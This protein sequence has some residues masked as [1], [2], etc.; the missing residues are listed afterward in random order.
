VVVRAEGAGVSDTHANLMAAVLERP[1]DDTARLVYADWLD[2]HADPGGQC[3]DCDGHGL[4]DD[5]GRG[6]S[7]GTTCEACRG[8]GGWKS[9]GHRERAEFIR[10]QCRLS[11]LAPH[12]ETS[13]ACAGCRC[14][15]CQEYDGLRRREG[16][17]WFRVREAVAPIGFH[18]S[19]FGDGATMGVVAGDENANAGYVVRRGFVD[20]IRLPMARFVGGP[21][22]R[23]E[24]DGTLIGDPRCDYC[25]GDGRVQDPD[26]DERAVIDCD[27]CDR[28]DCPACTGTGRTPGL[29]LAAVWGAH[30][31]SAVRISDREPLYLPQWPCWSYT[32]E[33][34]RVN[35]RL[36]DEWYDA[37]A[38]HPECSHRSATWLGFISREGAREAA[39]FAAVQLG[40]AAARRVTP[41]E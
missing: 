24:G 38:A 12:C 37:M 16:M 6:S 10:V 26:D 5:S 18:L 31:V 15:R 41:A 25:H 32:F 28:I 40:R 22:G 2:D 36:P 14:E 1:G 4:I 8:F 9:D 3:G 7:E 13:M 29:D 30:P 11:E 19:L 23:C 21:C 17:L 33:A 35:E 34:A 20:E 39:S 27:H